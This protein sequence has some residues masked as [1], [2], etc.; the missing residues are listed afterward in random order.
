MALTELQLLRRS[1]TQYYSDQD[2]SYAARDQVVFN[3]LLEVWYYRHV[4]N[5]KRLDKANQKIQSDDIGRKD[6]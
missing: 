4:I 6:W 3:L 2:T 1:A 5:P